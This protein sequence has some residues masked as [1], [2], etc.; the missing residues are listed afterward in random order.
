MRLRLH[1]GDES[2]L[3]RTARFAIRPEPETPFTF[4]LELDNRTET[5]WPGSTI[6]SW[7]RKVQFY[8]KYQD[9]QAERFRVFGPSQPAAQARLANMLRCAAGT[10]PTIPRRSL[11]Y[12]ES[13]WKI[14]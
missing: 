4:Y 5:V 11:V 6:D 7:G 9:A 13:P 2:L 10:G 1:V 3:P 12:M 8:E 14:C